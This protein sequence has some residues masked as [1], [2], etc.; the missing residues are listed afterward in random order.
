MHTHQPPKINKKRQLRAIARGRHSE[1][2]PNGSQLI[3]YAFWC[4]YR[5]HCLTQKADI[6]S[7]DRRAFVND[8]TVRKDL[9][10][11]FPFLNYG[12]PNMSNAV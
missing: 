9:E 4:V 10:Y 11:C 2:P 7:V 1:G 6:Y 8:I 3:E 12:T 5:A